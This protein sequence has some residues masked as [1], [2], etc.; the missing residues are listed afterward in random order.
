[1]GRLQLI[2]PIHPGYQFASYRASIRTPEGN[3]IWNSDLLHAQQVSSGK[4]VI[5]DVPGSILA[6][7]DYIVA[8]QGV[9]A[10]GNS[11]RLESYQFSVLKQ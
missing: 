9:T 4:A 10:A 8:L 3:E 7:E 5:L 1:L 11:E 6:S 2:S